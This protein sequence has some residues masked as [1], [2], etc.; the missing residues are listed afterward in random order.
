M[1]IKISNRVLY[2]FIAVL[3]L[4]SIIGVGYASYA[5][6]TT[7]VGHNASDI[8]PG[9]MEGPIIIKGQLKLQSQSYESGGVPGIR[10]GQV[11]ENGKTLCKSDGTDCL[12]LSCEMKTYAKTSGWGTVEIKTCNTLCAEI[13]KQCV[14]GEWNC[15]RQD[16][17]WGEDWQSGY[18]CGNPTY[19]TCYSYNVACGC[20]DLE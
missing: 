7:G 1:T 13:G 12:S 4:V 6:P 11:T 2:T 9:S 3:I 18:S 14:F 10:L 15:Q 20:C 16:P 8:G 19:A 5:N 17:S